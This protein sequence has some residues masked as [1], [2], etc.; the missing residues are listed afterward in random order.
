MH[1]TPSVPVAVTING[2]MP[3]RGLILQARTA[4]GPVGRF[5]V[6]S[7]G[8]MTA[9]CT[10]VN[11]TVTHKN[12]EDKTS[13]ANFLWNAPNYDVGLDIYFL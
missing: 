11:D 6:V 8:F 2:S 13:P 5:R 9:T 1:Y 7:D 4:T 10:S 3:F 12:T